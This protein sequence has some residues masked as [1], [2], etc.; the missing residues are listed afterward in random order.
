MFAGG[1]KMIV[2]PLGGAEERGT[3]APGAAGERR[4]QWRSQECEL[5][6][7]LPCPLSLLPFP[8][9]LPSPF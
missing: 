2:T 8:S 7:P 3:V 9:P 4:K 5:G 1:R 6:F